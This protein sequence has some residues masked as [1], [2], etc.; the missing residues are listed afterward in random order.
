MIRVSDFSFSYGQERR[1][2][3]NVNL[4]INSGEIVAMI[5]ENGAGKSTLLKSIGG[6]LSGSGI[7]GTVDLGGKRAG[8]F[9]QDNWL[10]PFSTCKAMID[11]AA[12]LSGKRPN[13]KDAGFKERIAAFGLSE[14]LGKRISE[15]SGGQARR[16]ALFSAI[17]SDPD[18]LLMDEPTSDLDAQTRKELWSTVTSNPSRELDIIVFV[19][20]NFSEVEKYADRILFLKGGKIIEDGSVAKFV[21]CLG[22]T[23]LV[24]SARSDLDPTS[25]KEVLATL[26][27]GAGYGL[28][29]RVT[30]QEYRAF[31]GR[32]AA[33]ETAADME[34]LFEMVRRVGIDITIREPN[35]QDYYFFSL[36]GQ[37]M[38]DLVDVTH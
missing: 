33:N 10:D 6:V 7:V 25:W 22:D 5:G 17:V 29:S 1:A 27:H 20:H 19:S 34:S 37:S 2:I 38:Q 11:L 9:P 36:S 16:V 21:S 3:E 18:I 30:S 26:D 8:Y 13:W 4:T 35:L 23:T 14:I 24:L 31:R 15:L 32:E 12:R 28:S